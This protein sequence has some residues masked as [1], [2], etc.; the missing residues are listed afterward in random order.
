[1]R[2]LE[3]I[4]IETG[5]NL[6]VPFYLVRDGSPI[7]SCVFRLPEDYQEAA[8]NSNIFERVRT[9]LITKKNRF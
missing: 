2:E 8:L 4:D 5:R 6:V 3:K 1:M 7:S 9:Y